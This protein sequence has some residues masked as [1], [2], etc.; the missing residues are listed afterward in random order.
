MLDKTKAN[1]N[2]HVSC[3]LGRWKW[4]C[5]IYSSLQRYFD[6]RTSNHSNLNNFELKNKL[7]IYKII[8]NGNFCFYT[9]LK[10][11]SHFKWTKIRSPLPLL[12]PMIYISVSIYKCFLS[13]SLMLLLLSRFSDWENCDMY[14]YIRNYSNWEN[15]LTE[16]PL[17]DAACIL[18]E[19]PDCVK[20]SYIYVIVYLWVYLSFWNILTYT[21]VLFDD[22][23]LM[24]LSSLILINHE[25]VLFQ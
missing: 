12:A 3:F 20:Y 14:N 18:P 6:K 5:D 21:S 15:C 25:M 11:K 4:N 2:R 7:E 24:L 22:F 19:C 10:K 16:G 23:D 9:D 13:L 1:L 17:T 8:W